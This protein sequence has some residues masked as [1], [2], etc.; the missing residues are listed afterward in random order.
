MFLSPRPFVFDHFGPVKKPQERPSDHSSGL[1]RNENIK[2]A[3][4][5]ASAKINMPFPPTL[6]KCISELR[7]L[8]HSITNLAPSFVKQS[9]RPTYLGAFNKKIER[10]L[11]ESARS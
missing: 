6:E 7:E 11:G 4:V 1:K 8:S 3:Y 2:D 5:R 9:R 10:R